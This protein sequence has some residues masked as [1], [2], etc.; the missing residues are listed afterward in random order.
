MLVSATAAVA[1]FGGVTV[2]VGA[3]FSAAPPPAV[4]VD[5]NAAVLTLPKVPASVTDGFPVSSLYRKAI[6]LS[7]LGR[8]SAPLQAEVAR[9]A[10][11]INADAATAAADQ[12][13]AR[14][15]SAAAAAASVAAQSAAERYD[16]LKTVIEATAVRLY[17]S[18]GA[19]LPSSV[20]AT[21][22]DQLLWAQDYLDTVVE[23]QGALRARAAALRT[24]RAELSIRAAA[25]ARA[26]ADAGRAQ[27]LL[28]AAQAASTHLEAE[29][30]ALKIGNTSAIVADHKALATQEKAELTSATA[31]E[32]TPSKP[33][34]APLPT[35]AVAL[36]WVFAE[37]GRPYLWGGTGPARFDCS[38]LTQ[39]AWNKAGVTIPR[40]AAAQDAW[41]DP[42]P[43]SQ[44][45]PGDLVFYGTSDIHHV[46]MYIGGG[47][48]INAPHTGTVIQV[49]P[50][51]WSDLAGFGRVH[52]DGAPIAVHQLPT[53]GDPSQK[54]VKT[55][56]P[57]PSESKPPKPKGKAKAPVSLTTTTTTPPTS[58]A[59]TTTT[60]T[61][62]AVPSTAVPTTAVPSTAP[63]TTL[64]PT[65]LPDSTTTVPE[66][67]TTSTTAPSSSP[68]TPD[69]TGS[70]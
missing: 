14:V 10:A 52:A 27:A 7:Q 29:L 60:S 37:L 9:A 15:A 21:S 68:T 57:V 13:A 43:L 51:W 16:A 35:T 39:Y 19:A 25:T 67:T 33:L 47:L 8:S 30:V 22:A 70:P 55:K 69:P 4:G 45:L 31:L 26:T 18:G 2:S 28:T 46:G 58:T 56:K 36:T 17:I 12:A 20:T 66:S 61:T 42:V 44:L 40:V 48:M 63:P 62:A 54:V 5:V 1:V 24:N 3:T 64:P 49:S 59:S 65:T 38:G 53:A 32:F 6:A 41:T 23:P 50:I 11:V 34:P